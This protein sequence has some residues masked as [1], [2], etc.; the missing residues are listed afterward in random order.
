MTPEMLG[1]I[2]PI[3]GFSIVLNVLLFAMLI[4]RPVSRLVAKHILQPLSRAMGRF[5]ATYWLGLQL[6]IRN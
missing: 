3:L 5:V 4:F 1:A 2:L 6:V